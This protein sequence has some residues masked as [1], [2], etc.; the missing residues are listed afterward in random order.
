M[1]LSSSNFKRDLWLAKYCVDFRKGHDGLLAEVYNMG[2]SPFRGD[3]VI[4]I[5]RQNKSLKVVYCDRNGLWISH[6]RFHEG[7][8]LQKINFDIKNSKE[9]LL[10]AEL[11]LIID[12]SRYSITL[13]K[14]DFPKKEL[15]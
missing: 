2:L 8:I 9:Q 5:G 3:V 11:S 14:T 1:I 4:F 12:G 7:K 13:S 15:T 6:K 10:E